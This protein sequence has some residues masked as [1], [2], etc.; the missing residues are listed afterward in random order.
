MATPGIGSVGRRRFGDPASLG[1]RRNTVVGD[2]S[3]Q[4]HAREAMRD[5]DA[6]REV[7]RLLV[8]SDALVAIIATVLVLPLK[9]TDDDV[10]LLEAHPD[11]TVFQRVILGRVRS[12]A[13]FFL[14]L[15]VVGIMWTRHDAL[16]ARLGT[17]ALGSTLVQLVN[18]V[19]L[20]GLGLVPFTAS[21]AVLEPSDADLFLV[22]IGLVLVLALA[23]VGTVFMQHTRI[24][25]V[26]DALG[27]RPFAARLRDAGF[28]ASG[29]TG[30]GNGVNELNGSHEGNDEGGAT[31]VNARPPT[32]G[33]TARHPGEN[34][35][36]RWMAWVPLLI[37]ATVVAAT[38]AVAHLTSLSYPAALILLVVAAPLN[39]LVGC[40]LQVSAC[41]CVHTCVCA[42]VCVCVGGGVPSDWHSREQRCAMRCSR[43]T[44]SRFR[45]GKPVIFRLGSHAPPPP[46]GRPSS[47][48]SVSPGSATASTPS[49]RPW[50]CSTSKRRRS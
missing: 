42:Y 3:Q 25:V 48:S 23:L 5:P 22:S 26:L 49:R 38:L 40:G 30:G 32:V 28:D 16:F 47:A 21:V 14:S 17:A 29:D 9:V 46:T 45:H 20:L 50:S 39:W 27:R 6:A 1:R 18:F 44:S 13:V 35:Y 2:A 15:A 24:G 31:G 11:E 7:P 43:V 36:S 19:F 37:E 12:Y 4:W 8:F 33:F 34:V 10:A 41:L